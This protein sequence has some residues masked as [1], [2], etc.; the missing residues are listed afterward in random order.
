[1]GAVSKYPL[2]MV[3]ISGTVGAKIARC[4]NI[5]QGSP[6]EEKGWNDQKNIEKSGKDKKKEPKEEKRSENWEKAV[7]RGHIQ[8]E[9][10]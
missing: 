9:G 6:E 10:I 4:L 5:F 3:P 7:E 1:M 8:N 2:A